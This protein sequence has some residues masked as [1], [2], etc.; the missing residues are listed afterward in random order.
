MAGKLLVREGFFARFHSLRVQKHV[1]LFN[2]RA[3]FTRV[4][5]VMSGIQI[6]FF[7]SSV[8]FLLINLFWYIDMNIFDFLIAPAPCRIWFMTQFIV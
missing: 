2:A 1:T 4:V 6:D 8:T 5:N 3:D 7:L